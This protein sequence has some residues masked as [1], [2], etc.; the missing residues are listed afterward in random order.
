VIHVFSVE[1]SDLQ[2]PTGS[3]QISV[4]NMFTARLIFSLYA[5]H[6]YRT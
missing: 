1:T 5:I 6:G 4:I 2:G 3:L